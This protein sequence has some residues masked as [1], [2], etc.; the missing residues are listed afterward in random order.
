MRFIDKYLKMGLKSENEVFDYLIDTLTKTIRTYDY[1]VNWDK[2]KSDI[3][4][5]EV[6]L[7]ILNTLIGKKDIDNILRELIAKYPEIV[8]TIPLLLACKGKTTIEVLDNNLFKEY[9]FATKQKYS[10]QEV[11]N[12]IEFMSKSGL[13]DIL[14][15]KNIK[16]VKDYCFGVEVG[17]DTNGRKNRSGK[18]MEGIVEDYLTEL[19]K[20][21]NLPFIVQATQKKIFDKFQIEIPVDKSS[22]RFDFAV[23]TKNKLYLIEVNYYSGGGSKLKAVA[24][25]FISVN[26]LLS[27]NNNIGFIWI[28]EGMGWYTAKQP[29]RET[30]DKIDHTINLNMIENGILEEIL[31]KEL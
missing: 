5:I 19:N 25:E 12:I 17:V 30:F 11:N 20:N 13:F 14:Q 3:S 22:R 15:N 24:G 18:I 7:N 2:I 6:H 29:L 16:D 4:N 1:Y 31:T 8:H 21:R 26:N 23:K 27:N 9:K 28:T 10:D